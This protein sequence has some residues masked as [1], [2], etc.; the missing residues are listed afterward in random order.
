MLLY[1]NF[2]RDLTMHETWN[3]SEAN[4]GK[5]LGLIESGTTYQGR[6]TDLTI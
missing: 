5:Y 1:M 2:T 4:R 3:G 6:P